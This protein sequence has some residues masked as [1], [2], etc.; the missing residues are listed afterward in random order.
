MQ[1]VRCDACGAKAILAASRCPKCAQSL[2]LRDHHGEF[3]ALGHCKSCGSHYLLSK[4]GCK[5]CGTVARAPEA[6]RGP[7]LAAAAILALVVVA[8]G[9]VLAW[10]DGRFGGSSPAATAPSAEKARTAVAGD[11]GAPRLQESVPTVSAP[12]G[13]L[14]AAELPRAIVDS[15]RAEETRALPRGDYAGGEWI[16]MRATTWV[17]VRASPY[18][19]A[20]VVG[21]VTPD[22]RVML[23]AS[24]DGWRRVQAP[25]IAGWVDGRLFEA[26]GEGRSPST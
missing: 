25:G 12:E 19:N 3:V 8:G 7:R 16:A 2:D 22:V 23:G 20:A 15:A 26:A 14:I 13:M 18:R 21:V 10:R 5:W 9:T 17:N 1:T 11:S 24:R 6:S 4:G